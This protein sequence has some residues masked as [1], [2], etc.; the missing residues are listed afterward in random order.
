MLSNINKFILKEDDN[1]NFN[2][3]KNYLL[4][5]ELVNKKIINKIQNKRENYII[6]TMTTVTSFQ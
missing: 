1:L 3:T 4:F 6:K 5:G 2:E